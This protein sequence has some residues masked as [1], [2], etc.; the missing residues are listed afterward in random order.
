[1]STPLTLEELA[2]VNL[3]VNMGQHC[4]LGFEKNVPH[5]SVLAFH[6]NDMPQTLV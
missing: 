5:H 1:M 6:R 2:P 4:F 3:Q